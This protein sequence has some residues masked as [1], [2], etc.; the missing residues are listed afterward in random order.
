MESNHDKG[1]RERQIEEKLFEIAVNEVKSGTPKEA[2]WIRAGIMSGDQRKNYVLLRVRSMKDAMIL[3]KSD[4]KQPADSPSPIPH[5]IPLE[6]EAKPSSGSKIIGWFFLFIGSLSLLSGLF[7]FFPA[8]LLGAG[9]SALGLDSIRKD[10]EIESG[11]IKSRRAVVFAVSFIGAVAWG[12]GATL[13][14]GG[15][16]FV[17]SLIGGIATGSFALFFVKHPKKQIERHGLILSGI[18]LVFSIISGGVFGWGER[19]EITAK[20]QEAEK[21]AQKKQAAE[22]AEQRR[23]DALSPEERIREDEVKRLSEE[24]RRAKEEQRQQAAEERR[25]A[26]EKRQ[27]EENAAKEERRRKAEIAKIVEKA[28]DDVDRTFAYA[29]GAAIKESLRDPSSANNVKAFVAPSRKNDGDRVLCMDMRAKNGF[30][31]MSRSSYVFIRK[32][33]NIFEGGDSN[34]FASLWN[35]ECTERYDAKDVTSSVR[36]SLGIGIF[37]D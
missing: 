25:K 10:S 30:G 11:F 20:Q 8:L 14:S 32:K 27:A 12:I 22:E 4:K 21:I 26:E 2:L 37:A 29:V 5:I 15:N 1:A 7:G 23:R 34:E 18:L 19:T 35:R 13:L 33:N 31:G 6:P 17:I 3:A 28:Q 9:L 24:K 36:S 16:Y